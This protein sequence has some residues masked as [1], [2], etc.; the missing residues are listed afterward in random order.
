MGKIVGTLPNRRF[1][2]P[3]LDTC[4]N[5]PRAGMKKRW[6]MSRKRN[7]NCSRPRGFSQKNY[8]KRQKR[9]GKYLEGFREWVKLDEV[10][11]MAPAPPPYPPPTKIKPSIGSST[12]HL[13]SNP[14]GAI[15]TQR[16]LGSK[17]GGWKVHLRTGLDDNN[18]DRAYQII[19][20]LVAKNGYKWDHKK[21]H[22]GEPDQKDITIYCGSRSEANLAAREIASSEDLKSLLLPPGTEILEDDI[23]LVPG[24]GIYG[25]FDVK[26]LKT[27][28]YEFTQY[29]CKGWA[30]LARDMNNNAFSKSFDKNAAC[31]RSYDALKSLF[32]KDFTG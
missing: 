28:P 20:L 26:N 30:M 31:Q 4:M 3:A 24:T 5:E 25:R 21:L 18:R 9:G 16:I 11:Q 13:Y 29:G 14:S 6:S 2:I 23:E 22:G 12:N 27:A 19:K 7:V 32:G 10:G 15:K 17:Q 1:F 8:C